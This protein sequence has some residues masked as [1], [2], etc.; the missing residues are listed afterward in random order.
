[1][2]AGHDTAGGSGT[3]GPSRPASVPIRVVMPGQLRE[4]A[5]VE[6]AVTVHVDEPVTVATTLD[7]L[8]AVHPALRGTI[9]DRV[10]GRRRAMI[11]IYAGGEDYSDAPADPLPQAVV[12]G[13]EALRLVGAI[14]GG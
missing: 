3:V 2:S 13:R 14:A 4:L 1:M 6:G 11:R 8:E 10:T 7:A 12:D 9:R 5:R